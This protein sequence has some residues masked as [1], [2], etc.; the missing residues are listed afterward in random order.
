MDDEGP[1]VPVRAPR[2]RLRP[3]LAQRTTRAALPGSGLGLAIVADA[4]AHA[5]RHGRRPVRG[6]ARRRGTRAAMTLPA[7]P[8]GADDGGDGRRPDV[9]GRARAPP[10]LP[11]EPGTYRF[12]DEA[13][14][15]LYVGRAGDLRRRVASYWGAL[16]DR[17][18]LR[19]MVA[20]IVAV[21]ALVC[22]S[23]H[24]AAWVERNLLERRLPRWNRARGGL[25]VPTYLR[26]TS[27]AAGTAARRGAPAV[28]RARRRLLRPVPRRR[29]DPARR[30]R[31]APGAPARVR[32][33]RRSAAPSARWRGC[34]VSTTPGCPSSSTPCPPSC[35]GARR[36]GRRPRRPAGPPGR[37]RRRRSSSRSRRGCR[38][39]SPR[40]TGSL[41]RN[42]SRSTEAATSR[43]SGW[44]DGV[45]V[46]FRV[47]GGRLDGW[48][49]R[50]GE[51]PAG[52]PYC[53]DGWE[54]FVRRNAELAAASAAVAGA[55]SGGS[56]RLHVA[57][58]E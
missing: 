27:S 42:G 20:Q 55:G 53:P 15:V 57:V 21:E 4:V 3:V 36:R 37:R 26:L 28:V 13:G 25:E 7:G 18:R 41:R 19:R 31:A 38:R 12:R 33:P 39:S 46:S 14:R 34:A 49:Q 54:P 5:A 30:L 32:R 17:P 35:T 58:G 24:E 45:L 56:V 8:S 47:R 40:S 51:P 11:S 16:R 43:C 6:G 29:P 44:S 23:E 1:G 9:V 2:R 52:R 48:E 22:A 50:D 10:A